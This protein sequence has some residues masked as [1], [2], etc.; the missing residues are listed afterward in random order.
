M[1][2]HTLNYVK[3]ASSLYQ[4]QSS[5][6]AS[7]EQDLKLFSTTPK[8]ISFTSSSK[9]QSIRKQ[10]AT[11]QSIENYSLRQQQKQATIKSGLEPNQNLN[12]HVTFSIDNKS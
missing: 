7:A 5:K 6:S 4:I 12:I 3:G 10:E 1:E 11:T 2:P 8:A 9:K